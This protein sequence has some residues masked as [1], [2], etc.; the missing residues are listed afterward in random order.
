M[1]FL[2]ITDIHGRTNVVNKLK[3]VIKN[4]IDYVIVAGDITHF[5][6]LAEALRILSSLAEIAPVLFVPGNC[7]PP[8]LL[9]HNSFNGDI[10]NVH[11][12]VIQVNEYSIYGIGGSIITPFNT[13]IEYREDEL[14]KFLSQLKEIDPSKTIIVTHNP[15]YG[16][17]D[18]T[19]SGIHAG[20]KVFREFLEEKKPLLWITGHIHE[21]QGVEKINGTTIINPGPLFKRY[22]A[23]IT[24]EKNTIDVN[25]KRF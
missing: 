5:G 9:R 15:P 23:L 24:I 11:N 16:I 22:Y 12:K 7:D 10:Y 25:I 14:T 21:A 8:E 17:L 19:F 2:A 3:G 1:R 18:R 20:S 6:S 4:N 13:F